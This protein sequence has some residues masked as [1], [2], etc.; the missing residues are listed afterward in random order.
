MFALF[1]LMMGVLALA[2][3]AGYTVFSTSQSSLVMSAVQRNVAEMDIAAVLLRQAVRIVDPSTGTAHV[4]MG[5]PLDP[6]TGS[7]RTIIPAW[8]AGSARTPWGVPFGYCPYAPVEG[9]TTGAVLAM[10]RGDGGSTYQVQTRPGFTGATDE[11]YVVQG[12]RGSHASDGPDAPAV[13]AFIVSPA[14]NS[15]DVPDCADIAWIDGSWRAAGDVQGTV[16]A[17]A[18]V[19]LADSTGPGAS[20]SMTRYV[21]PDGAGKGLYATAPETLS[22]ALAEWKF[23]RPLAMTIRLAP[24]RYSLSSG[25]LDLGGLDEA[26][27]GRSL[28]LVGSG[29]GAGRTTLQA[30]AGSWFRFPVDATLTNI[31]VSGNLGL[32]AGT[33]A[34]L[35]LDNV[36]GSVVRTTGG[37]VIL[38]PGTSFVSTAESGQFPVRITDGTLIVRPD[39]QVAINTIAGGGAP[40]R[41]RGSQARIGGGLAVNTFSS[42][43]IDME[44]SQVTVTGTGSVTRNGATVDPQTLSRDSVSRLDVAGTLAAGEVDLGLQVETHS[45]S[46]GYA[47][48]V[49]CPEGMMAIS[50]QCDSSAAGS[51][52]FIGS[53]FT[54][55][56]AGGQCRWDGAGAM[57]D[58]SSASVL[59]APIR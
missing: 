55:E 40:I 4:P 44:Q 47:C 11:P 41:L 7:G 6:D 12:S 14:V 31:T 36:S 33:G 19:Q 17:I 1:I 20:A 10:V 53:S 37:T 54:T 24:G 59:C 43:L 25:D 35:Y 49:S 26:S 56:R 18:P 51:P 29:S 48:V 15:R 30:A 2:A 13:L 58:P 22:M 45:C 57:P 42:A 46:G 27:F 28:R 9:N 23:F 16:R 38:E 32:E 5:V 8:V 21:S 50:V 34:R 3:I 52:N 39:G